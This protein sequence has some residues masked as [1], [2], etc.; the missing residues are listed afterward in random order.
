MGHDRGIDLDRASMRSRSPAP[1]AEGGRYGYGVQHPTREGHSVV[2]GV[3]DI[4]ALP[5]RPE[6]GSDSRDGKNVALAQHAHQVP[7]LGRV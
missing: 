6:V 4:V 5:R 3:I 7:R 1:F 2:R